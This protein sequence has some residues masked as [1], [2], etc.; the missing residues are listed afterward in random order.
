MDV[1]E[2]NKQKIQVKVDLEGGLLE[3]FSDTVNVGLNFITLRN[4]A[5]WRTLPSYTIWAF[6]E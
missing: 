5:S 6:G 2:R 3:A 4:R 1:K